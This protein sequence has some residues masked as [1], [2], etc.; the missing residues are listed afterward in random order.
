MR[1]LHVVT[2]VSPDGSFGGPLRVAV[3][4][5]R[6]LKER[7][8]TVDLVA[9]ARGFTGSLPHEY[10]GVPVTL[11]RAFQAVPGT[12]F[13]GLVSPGVTA[14]LLRHAGKYDVVHLHLAR[15]LVAL[16][17]ALAVAVRDV[18]Y[19]VH[20]HGM[21][22]ASDRLLAR[23]LDAVA[24]KPVMA[25]AGGAIALVEAERQ[26][27]RRL[28]PSLVDPVVLANGVPGSEQTAVELCSGAPDPEPEVLFLARVA[29]RKRPVEFIRAAQILAREFPTARFSLVGPDEDRG[30]AVRAALDDDDG[31]GRIR[32]EGAVSADQA[33]ARMAR[34]AVYVLPAV[35]EPFGM[36]LIEAM[37]VGVPTVC[38]HDCGI[39]GIVSETGGTVAADD[40]E[41]A[42]AD[43]VRELLQDPARRLAA[44]QAGRD[45]VARDF[46]MGAVAVRLEEIY[47]GAAG[48]GGR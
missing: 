8:H 7:G 31:R 38:N 41:D 4:H 16:P 37:A 11:Y 2:L 14:H 42:L 43:A 18:P 28:F 9:G 1:I 40:S 22:D 36:T 48:A 30:D 12:G 39:A 47:A 6:A 44:G 45:R 17:A 26:E 29:A 15:D 35:D 23:P 25:R 10:D 21:I 46:S 34:A 20:T 5:V 19:V 33:A 13:A 24:T 3:N 27:L 32:W